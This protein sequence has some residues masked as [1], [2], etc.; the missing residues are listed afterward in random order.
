MNTSAQ[1]YDFI[2]TLIQRIPDLLCENCKSYKSNTIPGKNIVA[3]KY[4]VIMT[5]IPKYCRMF[6]RTSLII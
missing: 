2:I 4:M 5:A 1:I 6:R 3:I